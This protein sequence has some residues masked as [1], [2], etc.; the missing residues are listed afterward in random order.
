MENL[1]KQ[2][3]TVRGKLF[4]TLFVVVM[5]IVLFLILVNFFVLEKYYQYI[6]SKKLKSVYEEINSY[7]NGETQVNDI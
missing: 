3:K 2:I 7:Y 5:S 6:K 1:K 4:L